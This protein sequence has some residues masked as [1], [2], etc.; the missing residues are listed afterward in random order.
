MTQNELPKIVRFL[1]VD[2]AGPADPRPNGVCPHC[3][4]EGRYTWRFLTE[5][6][7]TLGAMSGCL[8]LFPVSLVALEE[9]RLIEKERDLQKRY[10]ESAHLN[11][12][13]TKIMEAVGAFHR[14][15]ISEKDFE[16]TVRQ[17]KAAAQQWRKKKY[18]RSW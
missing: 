8:K 7:Q 12:W 17:Q 1:G 2:D 4:A 5:D 11:S 9:K 15:E 16:R 13:D 6:G 10:G 14:D 3:G 18:G